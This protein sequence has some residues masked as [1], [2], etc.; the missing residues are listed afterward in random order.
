MYKWVATGKNMFVAMPDLGKEKK[1][2]SADGKA[3]QTRAA[4]MS[5]VA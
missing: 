1:N 4:K 3:G 2:R 5:A